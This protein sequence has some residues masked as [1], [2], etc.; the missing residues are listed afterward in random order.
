MLEP[1]RVELARESLAE[2]AAHKDLSRD[3]YEIV[4][5]TIE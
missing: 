4:S 3:L 2:I 5:K 1:R